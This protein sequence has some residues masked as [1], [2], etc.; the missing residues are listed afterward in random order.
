MLHPVWLPHVP[1]QINRLAALDYGQRIQLLP[2]VCVALV[3]VQASTQLLVGRLELQ[4]IIEQLQCSLKVILPQ[5]F[6]AT[7][8]YIPCML[9]GLREPDCIWQYQP[10]INDSV[11]DLRN[12]FQHAKH[13]I[14]IW[15]SAQHAGYFGWTTI[16]TQEL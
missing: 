5:C 13:V 6:H 7:L 16:P 10:V 8:Q 11:Q 12:G 15:Y 14:G 1:V 3:V 2:H 9:L 4:A